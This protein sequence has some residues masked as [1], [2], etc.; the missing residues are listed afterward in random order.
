MVKHVVVGI[1]LLVCS[2]WAVADGAARQAAPNRRNDALPGASQVTIYD[3]DSRHL[4]NRLYAALFVRTT[5]DGQSYCLD[6]LDPLLWPSST[7]L[8][9]EPRHGLILSL[10]DEFSDKHGENLISQPLKRALFQHDLWTIFDWLADPD[11]EH[12]A[13][14]ARFMAQRRALGNRLAPII[15]RLALSAD[16]IKSLPDTYRVALASEAYPARHDPAHAENAFLPSDLFDANGPWVHFQTEGG[17]PYPFGKPTA[18]VHTFFVS[19]RSTFFVFMNLPGGRQ[20]TL[21]YM[22][23]VNSF[24]PD[25]SPHTRE[26]PLLTSNSGALP[27]PTGAQFALVR[28]MM[29]IDKTGKM[30][31]TRLIESVQIRVVRGNVEKDSDFYEFTL[32]RKDLFDGKGL[33]AAN[34]NE[35]TIPVFNVRDEDV[36]D[37]PRQTRQLREAVSKAGLKGPVTENLRFGCIACHTQSG[38]ASVSNFFHDKVPGLT[39]SERDKEVDRAIRWKGEKFNWG[40]F[41]GLTENREK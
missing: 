16:Q 2:S 25:V 8:L 6:D 22:Q 13:A 15:H 12:V 20:A 39:A 3:A 27:P 18:L 32:H 35:A 28:Q 5:D 14:R 37:L 1:I 10:L 31:P 21:D 9:T 7:Y 36:L 38:I 41:E 30:R 40:L 4:W 26:K 34:S 17:Q 23:K 19:G 33:R 29:L 24:P 11:A